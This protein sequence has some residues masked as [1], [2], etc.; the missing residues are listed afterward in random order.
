MTDMHYVYLTDVLSRTGADDFPFVTDGNTRRTWG[1]FTR[2]VNGWKLAFT[3]AG[4]KRAALYFTELFDSAAA[5]FGAWAAGVT[6]ILPADTARHTCD[7]LASGLVDACAGNFPEGL[8][9][10]RIPPVATDHPCT[11]S[12]D[13]KAERLE[14]FTSGS[15]GTPSL[16][17]KRLEQLFSEVDSIRQRP[18]AG[19]RTTADTLV[20]STVSQQHIYGLLYF[21]LWPVAAGLSVWPRR[22]SEPRELLEAARSRPHCAWV[23]SP[24]LLKR[25]PDSSDWETVRSHWQVIFSSGG[26]LSDEGLKRTILLTGL[27]PTEL[28]GSSE[29]GGIATRL[30]RLTPDGKIEN[31]PWLPLPSVQWK[32]ENGQLAVRGQQLRSDGWEVMSDLIE[33]CP[34]GMTFIHKGRTD[35]IVKIN[36]KRVSLTAVEKALTDT[37]YVK[38]VKALQLDDDRRSLAAVA[39]LTPNGI[40]FLRDHGKFALVQALKATLSESFERVCL[41]RR[42]RFVTALPENS[43]GKTTSSALTALFDPRA[44]QFIETTKTNRTADYLLTIPRN[45]PFFQGH[46]PNF[47]ILPGLTQ[48]QWAVELART[49][50]PLPPYFAGIANLK[51]M[52]PIFPGSRVTATLSLAED[53][54]SVSFTYASEGNCHAKGKLLFS[55]EAPS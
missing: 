43:M 31:L 47:A 10:P 4:V 35:R 24:A 29:A 40:A 41:P 19:G 17:T 5:L 25:L 9:L 2:A 18:E 11:D 7:R 28:L 8:A 42:W 52:K 34:G 12:L 13:E 32:T 27:S 50:F 53:G 36:E 6:A 14:L 21:L 45:L 46:F 44:L 38:T 22:I 3:R 39:S 20:L 37:P 51:F 1:E 26:P 15:T 23:A 54:R 49:G 55:D 33:V 16:V 30:R 48:I